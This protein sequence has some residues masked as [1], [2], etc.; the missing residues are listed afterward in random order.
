M[1]RF[2]SLLLLCLTVALTVGLQNC[3]KSSPD[4]VKPTTTTPPTSSTSPPTSVTTVTTTAPTV[5][6]AAAPTVSGI[7]TTSA[8]VSAVL[9][10]NGGAAITQHGF[11]YSKTNQTPTLTDSKL[12]LGATTGPF[13]LTI[14]NKLTG[15]D[16][17]ATY[18][19]RAFATNDKGTSYGGSA[20][21]KMAASAIPV[22]AM[23]A[24]D[25]L[26]SYGFRANG[27]L[28]A[29]GPDP[30]LISQYG[31]VYSVT[32]ATPVLDG[33][34][35]TAWKIPATLPSTFVLASYGMPYSYVIRELKAGQPF[36]LRAFVSYKQTSEDKIAYSAVQT[37]QTPPS[38]V[39]TGSWKEIG[40]YNQAS[41]DQFVTI[42][43]KHYRVTGT[44][45]LE[46]NQLTAA[47][48]RKANFP[49][50]N[51]RIQRAALGQKVYVVN[52]QKD[53]SS[54]V[55]TWE[56]DVAGN[57]WQRRADFPGPVR[58]RGF[59]TAIGSKL[60][61]G[62]GVNPSKPN[63]EYYKDWW[64][65]NPATNQ[66]TKKA[67]YLAET[68]SNTGGEISGKLYLIAGID[69]GSQDGYSQKVFAYD[70]AANAWQQLK[71]AP[72]GEGKFDRK[73][74]T[75]QTLNNKLYVMQ[76][77]LIYS[78]LWEY[79]GPA[80]TWTPRRDLVP[81]LGSLGFGLYLYPNAGKLYAIGDQDGLTYPFKLFEFT[82]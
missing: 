58:S 13:P 81:R 43:D 34:G 36:Y 17:N 64:E 7:T 48:T 15:L 42:G 11:V 72:R 26:T 39:Q 56:F 54:P 22:V 24:A 30:T 19:V 10:G 76:T 18:Y 29:L 60:Y 3:K 23:E 50:A 32:N 31:F 77:N 12:E 25:N 53:A 75:R 51:S 66:W 38:P 40:P 27:N 21:L 47:T 63:E 71:N 49:G 20:Q 28:T 52:G 46:V 61:Y 37:V 41:Y 59:V 6:T 65:Y 67:D 4:P 55:E 57:I 9:D 73:Y 79:D 35:V 1:N 8:T 68:S 80:D 78:Q 44:N 16:P 74:A 14:T 82:P 45:T 33:A 70:P 2:F 69:K 5:N 62:I